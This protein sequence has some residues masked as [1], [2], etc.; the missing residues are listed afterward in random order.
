MEEW[1][2]SSLP[3]DM[4]LGIPEISKRKLK[5]RGFPLFVRSIFLFNFATKI[6]QE[7]IMNQDIENN[8]LKNISVAVVDDHEVV[9]EG[10]KS[11]LLKHGVGNVEAFTS[12]TEILKRTPDHSFDVYILDV[13]LPDLN[14]S[15][16]IE[17]IREQQPKAKILI[18]TIHEEMWVVNRM[19]ENKVDGVMYKTIHLDQLLEAIIAV[20]DGQKFY[21]PKFQESMNKLQMQNVV[22]T[23][24]EIDVVR[25]IAMGLST[26]EI[27]HQL[28]ISENT[29]ESH[30]QKIFEKLGVRNM[31]ELIVKAIADGYINVKT[32]T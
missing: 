22:L 6:I 25:S 2:N 14:V 10:Y 11:F 31:A 29:V 9:L 32:P 13:E 4:I 28:F 3:S 12:A 24:R 7:C 23:K 15:A 19:I 30:R 20:L 16:L 18:N 1:Q 5:N 26:K 21:C 17:N 27:A 8:R